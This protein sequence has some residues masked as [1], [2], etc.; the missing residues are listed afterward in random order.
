MH[1]KTNYSWDQSWNYRVCCVQIKYICK[2][3]R[4]VS[5]LKMNAV[6]NNVIFAVNKLLSGG[7]V[8]GGAPNKELMRVLTSMVCKTIC[9]EKII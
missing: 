5:K 7:G 3:V 8:G 4:A 1:L 6:L 9:E 2:I